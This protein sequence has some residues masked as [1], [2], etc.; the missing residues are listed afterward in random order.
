[1]LKPGRSFHARRRARKNHDTPA[2][3]A[4]DRAQQS[5]LGAFATDVKQN[6]V[7]RYRCTGE[8]SQLLGTSQRETEIGVRECL[9]KTAAQIQ[10]LGKHQ[11]RPWV[12]GQVPGRAL[13]QWNGAHARDEKTV[14]R[15][16]S[17]LG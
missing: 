6:Q 3:F 9:L 15:P 1:M 13:V 10:I 2:A 7:E 8:L 14:E 5:A 12:L 11:N 17:L 16:R 4:Q